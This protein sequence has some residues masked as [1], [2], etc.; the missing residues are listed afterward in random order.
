MAGPFPKSPCSTKNHAS[1]SWRGC[2]AARATP[3]A[4]TPRRCCVEISFAHFT[5]TG[6]Q[7]FPGHFLQRVNPRRMLVHARDARELLA[8]PGDE[9]FADRKSTRLNSS[10][11]GISY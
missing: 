4:N 5:S 9:L 8:V 2:S 7:K 11:L 1:P 3:R 6:F 10:H